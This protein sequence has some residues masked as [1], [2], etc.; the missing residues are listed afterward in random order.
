MYIFLKNEKDL[1]RW[2]GSKKEIYPPTCLRKNVN[3][4]VNPLECLLPKL[5]CKC[6]H[7]ECNQGCK[8]WVQQVLFAIFAKDIWNCCNYLLLQFY[9]AKIHVSI[10]SVCKWKLHIWLQKIALIIDGNNC[11]QSAIGHVTLVKVAILA[12][13]IFAVYT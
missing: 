11:I 3:G 13:K 8:F 7:P 12:T 2:E 1:R 5:H 10:C 9:D 4:C 6:L